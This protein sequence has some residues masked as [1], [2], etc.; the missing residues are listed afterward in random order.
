MKKI[1]KV[2]FLGVVGI[3]VLALS[4]I[5]LPTIADANTFSQ[6][7]GT[8]T[9]KVGSKNSNV[10]ALQRFLASDNNIYPEG[11]V[12]GY[13][14]SLTKDAV[15]QFQLAY[16]LS[17]DGLAGPA[18]KA[19]ANNIIETNK[20]IDLYAPSVNN[21][22]VSPSGT[23]VTVSFNSYELV[24][25]TVFYDVNPI[26]WSNWDDSKMSLD[27]PTISGMR[28]TD[29]NFSMNKQIVIN[30]LLANSN[31]NYMIT[32]TDQS[33]NTTVVLPGV[34]RTGQ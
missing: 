19:K 31:Y 5:V 3:F 24:K 13:F 4:F 8:T 25:A 10:T 15:I 9:L 16:N 7:S 21:V 12:T 22:S 28:S 23:N 18:T 17:A 27:V 29:S 34:F 20:G 6:I 26:N 30:N 1:T 2:T 11:R 33:G 14:G 32:L